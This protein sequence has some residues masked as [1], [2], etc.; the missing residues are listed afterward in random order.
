MQKESRAFI[1]LQR[2]K[3]SGHMDCI[4][5]SLALSDEVNRLSISQS[6]RVNK[7]IKDR[8][9]LREVKEKVDE[10]VRQLR[11]ATVGVNDLNLRNQKD[12]TVWTQVVFDAAAVALRLLG[13]LQT[14]ELQ[15]SNVDRRDEDD[16]IQTA[17]RD[18][19]KGGLR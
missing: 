8:D 12:K 17:E 9:I 5:E 3:E 10:A 2:L 4:R 19:K 15:P 1:T 16:W 7:H 13:S 18:M 14:F 11:V 6:E